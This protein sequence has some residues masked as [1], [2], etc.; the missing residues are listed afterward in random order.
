[1]SFRPPLHDFF[2]RQILT[3]RKLRAACALYVR[4]YSLFRK[5][6]R[7][8]TGC[9]VVNVF[10]VFCMS[11][12]VD[13]KFVSQIVYLIKVKRKHFLTFHVSFVFLTYFS[14]V[15][16]KTANRKTITTLPMLVCQHGMSVKIFVK[17]VNRQY[18]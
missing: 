2:D 6:F 1:M 8:P 16:C 10:I 4:H 14:V 13:W 15:G 11:V 7:R 9:F 18:N 3:K 12:H 5:R 17:R